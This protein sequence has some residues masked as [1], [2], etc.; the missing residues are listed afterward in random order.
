MNGLSKPLQ[1]F[2]VLGG[3]PAHL[4]APWQPSSEPDQRQQAQPFCV[5]PLLQAGA[6][7]LGRTQSPPPD[8]ATGQQYQPAK[9]DHRDIC[10]S[11][12]GRSEGKADGVEVKTKADTEGEKASPDSGLP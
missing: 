11:R 9:R 7:P 1:M 3:E 8:G 12:R 4:V 5:G 10:V 2:D 6:F